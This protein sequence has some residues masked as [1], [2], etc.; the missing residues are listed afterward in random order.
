MRSERASL[1]KISFDDGFVALPEGPM[2]C[3]HN[4]ASLP[5]ALFLSCQLTDHIDAKGIRGYP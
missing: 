2:T 4:K 3:G 5:F 1:C